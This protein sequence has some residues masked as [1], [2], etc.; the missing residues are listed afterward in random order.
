MKKYIL[1]IFFLIINLNLFAISFAD[2]LHDASCFS[3]SWYKWHDLFPNHQT[4]E[5]LFE[6]EK[7]LI[8]KPALQTLIY[9]EELS[10]FSEIGRKISIE[11]INNLSSG[12]YFVKIHSTGKT[13]K[14]LIIK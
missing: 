12:Y 3:P 2:S 14:L 5:E 6:S 1:A 7:N 8:L 9:T 11:E 4:V 10:V 13:Y